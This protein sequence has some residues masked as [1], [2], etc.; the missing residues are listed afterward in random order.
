MEA[1]KLME[2]GKESHATG[3]TVAGIVNSLAA[4]SFALMIAVG[5]SAY[6][7]YV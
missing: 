7:P 5:H 2:D 6:D 1:L 4:T 3:R